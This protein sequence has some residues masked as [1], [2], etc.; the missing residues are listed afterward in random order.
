MQAE[1]LREAIA[2]PGTA[3]EARDATMRLDA[4][5]HFLLVAVRNG[6]HFAQRVQGVVNDVRLGEVIAGFA[7]Q[8]PYA[9]DLRDVLTHL[10]EHVLDVAAEAWWR[11]LQEGRRRPRPARPSR[12]VASRPRSV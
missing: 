1:R 7:D 4:D 3:A 12:R 10:D 11:G 8:L 6:L 5:G 9:H 2:T